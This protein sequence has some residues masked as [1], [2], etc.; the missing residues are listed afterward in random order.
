MDPVT[1]ELLNYGV[2]GLGLIV[3]GWVIRFLYKE[4]Q[5]A[6]VEA[7]IERESMRQSLDGNTNV[8]RDIQRLLERK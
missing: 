2:M 7:K 8:L 3:A 5:A 6:R 4:T 1:K